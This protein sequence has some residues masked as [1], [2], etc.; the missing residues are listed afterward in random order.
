MTKETY[1]TAIIIA[2]LAGLCVGLSGCSI[3]QVGQQRQIAKLDETALKSLRNA[4]QII[5]DTYKV[6]K[7]SFIKEA[8]DENSIK[9][10][11]GDKNAT[12]FKPEMRISRWEDEVS[13]KIGIPDK[14][15]LV[16]EPKL[17][18]D[19]V[20]E[21]A[22]N[23]EKIEYKEPDI[24][25]HY[26]DIEPNEEH[27][28]GAFEY[29]VVLKDK[30]LTNILEMTI[31]TAGLDF[32]YQPKLT[33]AEKDEGAKRPENVVGSYAVY[34]S[35]KRDNII[36]Q[37]NY[38]TG[39]AFHIYRP[40]IIDANGDW[41]W[42]ELNIDLKKKELTVT[43]P[44]KFLDTKAY[45]I[46]VDPTFGYTSMGGSY[47][48]I[49][50]EYPERNY[51]RGTTYTLTEGATISGISVYSDSG[52]TFDLKL[53]IYQ[54]DGSGSN[55]HDLELSGENTDA[56][57]GDAGPWS[58]SITGSLLADDYI[59]SAVAGNVSSGN[60]DIY[61][62]STGSQNYYNSNGFGGYT[63][64]NPWNLTEAGTGRNY[65]I[66]ATYTASAAPAT[67]APTGQSELWFK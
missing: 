44:Q 20:G 32:F 22:I 65:S 49:G 17:G 25:Y 33:Q 35:S 50:A 57:S 61:Y 29:E 63:L 42:G 21:L 56:T 27:P 47:I 15:K 60:V 19:S 51:L 8:K 53:A 14:T 11:V 67:T 59:L 66:Y 24:E 2:L 18:S 31:E 10:E 37:T 52:G 41:V 16:A 62:D 54:E 64:P 23:E 6:E 30:P 40:K 13:M 26:Y 55:S 38:E 5:A 3:E 48:A 46:I 12:E 36:G 39:K 58:V 43:V 28:E 34:H 1:I 9:V 7:A 45:P 4:N